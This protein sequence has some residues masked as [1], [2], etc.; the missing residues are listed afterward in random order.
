MS[1]ESAQARVDGLGCQVK[2]YVL[3]TRQTP[4]P[5]MRCNLKKR[6]DSSIGPPESK[7]GIRRN[8][9]G[10]LFSNLDLALALETNLLASIAKEERIE[11]QASHTQQVSFEAIDRS[12]S[13]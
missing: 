6:S 5:E 3:H 11:S 7:Q 4:K 12:R 10:C 1:L 9:V 2:I 8:S 13:I